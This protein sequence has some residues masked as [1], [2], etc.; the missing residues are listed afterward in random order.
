LCLTPNIENHGRH[1]NGKWI[2]D[3]LT[4]AGLENETTR[5]ASESQMSNGLPTAVEESCKFPAASRNALQKRGVY[6]S[7]GRK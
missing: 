7:R 6:T 3:P 2:S 5:Y 1:A 4:T